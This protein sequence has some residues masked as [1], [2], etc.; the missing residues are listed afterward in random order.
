[1]TG[2]NIAFD[3][4]LFDVLLA[5]NRAA[6]LPECGDLRVVVKSNAT[7]AGNS[8]AMVTFTVMVD[9]EPKRV[10]AVTTLALFAQLC[11]VCEARVQFERAQATGGQFDG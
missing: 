9:G 11:R 1:M 8:A 3:D 6:G 10:Q 2:I 7:R 4:G 5:E